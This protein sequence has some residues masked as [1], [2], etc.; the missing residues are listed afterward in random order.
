MGVGRE[1]KPRLSVGE[2][3]RRWERKPRLSVDEEPRGRE[4]SKDSDGTVGE[5][6]DGSL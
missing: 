1:R 2:E 5:E 3:L 4:P 6:V